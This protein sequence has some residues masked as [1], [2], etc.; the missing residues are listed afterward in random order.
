MIDTP[1]TSVELNAAI[2][3]IAELPPELQIRVNVIAEMLRGALAND[4]QFE[5]ELAM[6]V[7]EAELAEEDEATTVVAEL[8]NG[9]R[10]Q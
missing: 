4:V 8:G 3:A 2:A 1:M 9:E 7:V 5:T 10:L 6:W